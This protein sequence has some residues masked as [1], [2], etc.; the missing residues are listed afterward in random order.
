MIGVCTV[1]AQFKYQVRVNVI[2]IQD[3]YYAGGSRIG[4]ETT[5]KKYNVGLDWLGYKVDE[6]SNELY[7]KDSL[8]RRTR[9]REQIFASGAAINLS[10]SF[11]FKRNRNKWVVG[12]QFFIGANKQRNYSQRQVYDSIHGFVPRWPSHNNGY[13][14]WDIDTEEKEIRHGA[15]L[16]LAFSLF[17]RMQLAINKHFTFS[18]EFQL[19]FFINNMIGGQRGFEMVPGFNFC[20]G[21]H[22]CKQKP[23]NPTQVYNS[24]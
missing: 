4:I 3:F 7:A 9:L 15:K 5:H 11:A 18:P 22:F 6:E 24:L 2:P 16:S 17:L 23:Q 10:R 19:P 8:F 12:S 21:Y 1:Q 13:Q 20:L 14:W